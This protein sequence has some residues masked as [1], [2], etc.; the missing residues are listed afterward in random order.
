MP[1]RVMRHTVSNRPYAGLA[2]NMADYE[3]ARAGF[4]WTAA[5]AE[6]AGLPS[7]GHLIGPFEVESGLLA[8][9]AVAWALR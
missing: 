9:E 5:A 2:P 6:L 1:Q 4:S 3:E 8:H 7:A